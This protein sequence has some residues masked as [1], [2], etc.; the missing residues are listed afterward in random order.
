MAQIK[1]KVRGEYTDPSDF[2]EIPDGGLRDSLNINVD[3]DSLAEPRRGKNKYKQISSSGADRGKS[4]MHYADTLLASYSSALSRDGTDPFTLITGTFATPDH[5]GSYRPKLKGAEANRNFY[6]IAKSGIQKMTA[7]AS[8]PTQ[9]GVPRGIDLNLALTGASGFMNDDTQVAYRILWGIRDANDNLILGAPSQRSVIANSAG[10]SKDVIVNFSI[11]SEITTSHFYRVYRSGQSQDATI[12]PNDELQLVLEDFPTSGEIAAKQLTVTDS[13][14]DDLRGETIY[15]ASSQEGIAQANDTPPAAKDI[16]VFRNMGLLSN[17]LQ[18]QSMTV[19]LL[20]VGGDNGLTYDGGNAATMTSGSAT[21][22]ALVSTSNLR[23]GMRVVGSKVPANTRILSVDTATQ[24]HMTA[25]ATSSGADTLE[26]FDT[27]LIDGVTY[28]AQPLENDNAG[29]FVV[30]TSGTPAQNISD[31]AQSLVKVINRNTSNTTVYAY[32]N[33]GFDELPGKIFIQKRALGASSFTVSAQGHTS[34]WSPDLSATQTSS[35]E[36]KRHRLHV[37]KLQEYEAWPL[38]QYYDIGAADKEILRIL[39]LREATIICKEDGFWRV[40]GDTPQTLQIEP[41]DLTCFLVSPESAKA[42]ANQIYCFSTQGFSSV[43]ETGVGVLSRNIENQIQ[44]LFGFSNVSTAIF[45]MSYETDR[46]YLCWVPEDENDE[47]PSIVHRYNTFTQQWTKWRM[48]ARDAMV[49]PT[50]DK[51][52]YLD[53]T[54]NYVFEERKDRSYTDYADED[55][56]VTVTS[57]SDTVITLDA[58]YDIE[59]G[60]I[61]T[62]S[63]KP[64]RDIIDV[65]DNGA[66][67]IIT[68]DIATAYDLNPAVIKRSY[69]CRVEFAAQFCGN[70]G[71]MKQVREVQPMLKRGEFREA[72]LSFRTD[73]K[74]NLEELEITGFPTYLWGYFGWGNVPWGGYNGIVKERALIPDEWQRN[75]WIESSFIVKEAFSRFELAGMQYTFEP[76]SERTQE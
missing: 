18:K 70:P 14:P 16:T 23:A 41:I 51:F 59:I 50:N 52:Y 27:I 8:T 15:T 48:P 72:T 21:V 3:R 45:A 75:S 19:T 71:I 24:I 29:D 44:P 17:T 22:T 68:V 62:Q 36:E 2:S 63:T 58:I 60:D 67:S 7:A 28:N 69:E 55:I 47:Y 11:P 13:T 26:F 1:N 12:E 57:V 73:L 61:I 5:G 25:N 53:A 56:A 6:F 34:C 32:Y 10:T 30:T 66:Q 54:T 49:N 9:A 46:A 64:F 42:L 74:T 33:S 20:S 65:T 43:N 40:V 4:L 38:T 37:S 39:P 76:M 31:T 35:A